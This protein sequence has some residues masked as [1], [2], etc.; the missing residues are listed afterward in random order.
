[1]HTRLTPAELTEHAARFLG[2]RENTKDAYRAWVV[3]DLTRLRDG[4]GI[5]SEAFGTGPLHAIAVKANPVVAILKELVA[6]GAGLECASLEEVELSRAAGCPP[7]RIVFDSPVKTVDELRAALA[8]GIVINVDNFDELERLASILGDRADAP[9]S[10][11]LRV[12]PQVGVGR[13]SMTSVAGDTSKFGVPLNGERDRILAA[14][15]RYPWLRGL[16]VHIGSQGCPLPLL[17][18]GVRRVVDLRETIEERHGEGRVGFVD[19]GGG[20]SAVYRETDHYADPR[21]YA[22]NLRDVCPTLF[23]GSV[24]LVTEFGRWLH[25]GCGFALSRVEYVKQQPGVSYVVQH[26]GADFLLR[27]VYRPEDWGHEFMLLDREGR[28]KEGPK[29]LVSIAG[30]LCFDGDFLARNVELA[31][32]EPGDWLLIRD[33][34][35]YSVSM[36]SRYCSRGMP[37]IVGVDGDGVFR[38]LRAGEAPEDVVAFWTGPATT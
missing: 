1:M 7:E 34:G 17:V 5:L 19:I 9:S 27:P 33:V 13:I 28:V 2:A 32:P 25:A 18:E 11:G 37:P 15:D 36:W 8:L 4:M 14:F 24:Q 16:H 12:N 21:T 30:P 35:A 26:L 6:C 3:H 29:T 22:A 10:I 38:T 31:L 20:L 23:D